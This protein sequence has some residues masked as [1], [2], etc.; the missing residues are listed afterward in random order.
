M[1]IVGAT[2]QPVQGATGRL[3]RKDGVAEVGA[4]DV[5]RAFTNLFNGKGVSDA[6]GVLAL[7]TFNAG[8]YRLEVQ[9]GAERAQDDVTLAGSGEQVLRIRLR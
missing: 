5:G 4:N 2:G 1:K 3:V 9:R 8:D 6:K 7:G